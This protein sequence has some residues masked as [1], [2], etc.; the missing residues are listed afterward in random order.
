[1]GRACA[2]L[3]GEDGDQPPVAGIEIEMPLV[4]IV[5]I[6]LIEDEGHAQHALPEIDRGLAIGAVERDVMHALHLDLPEFVAWHAVV[7]LRWLPFT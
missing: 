3:V 6:G 1:V 7:L 5:E 2:F 4:R